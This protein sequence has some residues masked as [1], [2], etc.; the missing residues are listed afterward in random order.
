MA[1]EPCAAPEQKLHCA[2]PTLLNN[3][4]RDTSLHIQRRCRDC[5]LP[6]DSACL[7]SSKSAP[8]WETFAG[9]VVYQVGSPVLETSVRL[10]AAV[11]VSKRR[12]ANCG[13]NVCGAKVEDRC[14]SSDVLSI[15]AN[16]CVVP[17]TPVSIATPMAHCGWQTE[18]DFLSLRAFTLLKMSSISW[19]W[20]TRPHLPCTRSLILRGLRL[21]GIP[22]QRQKG[23][24]RARRPCFQVSRRADNGRAAIVVSGIS[25]GGGG[26]VAKA[27]NTS[28]FQKSSQCT[29]SPRVPSKPQ[30]AERGWY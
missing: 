30:V 5:I 8:G 3:I 22:T 25:G 19:L 24:T 10:R 2:E 11:A 18:L 14:G 28:C 7:R 6:W 12:F 29:P 26:W 13:L 15:S 16:R 21:K 23:P 17:I 4:V 9:P 20:M 1:R 27:A